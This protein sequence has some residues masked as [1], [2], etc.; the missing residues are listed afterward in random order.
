MTAPPL[1]SIL[2][3]NH[4]YARYLPFALDSALAQS[5]PAVEVVVVDDGSTDDSR[6]VL[7]RYAGRIVPI[8]KPNGGQGSAIN[9][10]FQACRGQIVTFLDADDVYLPDRIAEVVAAF[11]GEPS[12]EWVF[13]ELEYIDEQGRE[14]PFERLAPDHRAGLRA[15]R[16]SFPGR[17]R[18]DLRAAFAAGRRFAY[19]MP[20]FS[21]LSFRRSALAQVLPCPS[22]VGRAGDEFPKWAVAGLFP[23]AHVGRTLALQRLHAENAATGRRDA[24]TT[25]LRYLKTAYYLRVRFPQLAGKTDRVFASAF[26]RL[27]GAGR[28]Q[29]AFCEE[30]RAYLRL[31]GP[32]GAV[33][34]LPRVARHALGAAVV[35]ATELPAPPTPRAP[36]APS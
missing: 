5:Y 33:A 12:A 16:R 6:D 21:A 22:G 13:H 26:G 11:Q 29:A 2:V 28:W 24:T 1:V 35:R 31:F 19:T 27:I 25:A 10:G 32:R 36:E 14:I 34:Q 23:G 7:T 15:R 20:A 9:A 8:L 4:N 18:I 3:V 17:S 30:G